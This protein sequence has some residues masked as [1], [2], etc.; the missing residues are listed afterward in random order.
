MIAEIIQYNEFNNNYSAKVE[1]NILIVFTIKNET[2]LR[3]GELIEVDLSTI[4]QDKFIISKTNQEIIPIELSKNDLHK[5]S[6]LPVHGG[7]RAPDD[8]D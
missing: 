7:S 5:L 6:E 8:I 4:L 3:L 1:N 2:S